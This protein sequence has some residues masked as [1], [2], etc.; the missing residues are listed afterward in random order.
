MSEIFPFNLPLWS[1]LTIVMVIFALMTG[2][3]FLTKGK[4]EGYAV[5]IQTLIQKFDFRKIS[6]ESEEA[7][8]IIKPL[9]E[10]FHVSRSSYQLHSINEIHHNLSGGIR[11]GVI[12]GQVWMGGDT[13]RYDDWFGILIRM[14]N[15]VPLMDKVSWRAAVVRI[16]MLPV[17]LGVMIIV[18]CALTALYYFFPQSMAEERD[19]LIKVIGG[20]S[21]LILGLTVIFFKILPEKNRKKSFGSLDA[22]SLGQVTS[23]EEVSKKTS[24]FTVE[25][26]LKDNSGFTV[27]VS[28]TPFMDERGRFISQKKL[29]QD[30]TS[31]MDQIRK[32]KV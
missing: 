29:I 32:M 8:E 28:M 16:R 27:L 6:L 30:T 1:Q 22:K 3:Y 13:V 20:S 15:A 19:H 24:A 21:L 26:F 4:H 14:T 31:I 7:T 12:H 9:E 11:V 17:V 5:L 2:I 25:G 10:I 23:I 18:M